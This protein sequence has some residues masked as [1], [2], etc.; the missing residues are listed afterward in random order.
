VL[1]HTAALSSDAAVRFSTASLT[2]SASAA[3]KLASAKPVVA[4]LKF[5]TKRVPFGSK[6][7]GAGEGLG[8]GDEP[9]IEG[10]GDG[11]VLLT[12]GEGCGLGLG[13]EGGC[14]EGLGAG[15]AGGGDGLGEVA[16]PDKCSRQAMQT[17][18]RRI[19]VCAATMAIKHALGAVNDSTAMKHTCKLTAPAWGYG[20]LQLI[21][22]AAHLAGT[23]R[24][25]LP[26]QD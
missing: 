16:L 17:E 23:A 6:V 24:S 20:K 10:E 22:A 21:N 1:T 5:A 18:K 8:L 11:E 7:T 9:L 2:T 15:L 12:A 26:L 13:L 14:G 3:D 4:M 25:L 19:Q